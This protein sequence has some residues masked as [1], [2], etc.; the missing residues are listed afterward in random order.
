M[1]NKNFMPKFNNKK[2]IAK[3]CKSRSNTAICICFLHAAFHPESVAETVLCTCMTN[4]PTPYC[5]AEQCWKY[6]HLIS[7]LKNVLLM[8]KFTLDF[9]W[10]KT[11]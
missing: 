1:L 8:K 4:M 11:F 3:H 9:N 6:F 5:S 2:K 10:N 7:K